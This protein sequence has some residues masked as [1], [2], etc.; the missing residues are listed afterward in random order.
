MPRTKGPVIS[1]IAERAGVSPA[2]VD[3]VI[4][5]RPGVRTFTRKRVLQAAAELGYLPQEELLDAL[6]PQQMRL[7]FLLPA[8]TNPYLQLLGEAV[9]V[10]AAQPSQDMRIKCFFIDSF[11]PKFLSEAL[12]RYGYRADGIAFMAIDHPLVREAVSALRAKRKHVV[13]IVSDISNSGRTAYVGLDNRAVGRTAA[14][15]LGRLAPRTAGKVALIAA[16]RTYRAHEEREMGFL[17]MMDE[18]YPHLSVVGTR[19]GHDNRDE[20]Y[21]L[22]L[23]LLDDYPDLVGIYNV[24]GSSDGVGRALRERKCDRDILFIGHGLTP[25]TRR[26][27][28]EEMMDVVITQN[29]DIVVRNALHIFESVRRQSDPTAGVLPLPM[30]VIVKENLP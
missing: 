20:N 22:T 27:L 9:K 28:V 17:S 10:V 6:R 1:D 7:V 5:K 26:L 3:R 15:L 13:A 12:H 25:D 24:G 19:E 14:Y 18:A 30:E 11:N 21:R 2:T 29:P 23:T 8:G 4:N 16:S